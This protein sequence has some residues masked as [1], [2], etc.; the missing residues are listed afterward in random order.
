MTD[1][2]RKSLNKLLREIDWDICHGLGMSNLQRGG[3]YY[4]WIKFHTSFPLDIS[5]AEMCKELQSCVS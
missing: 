4:F 5:Y 1:I 3:I 2:E